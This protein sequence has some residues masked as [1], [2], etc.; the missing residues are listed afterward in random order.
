MEE[1]LEKKLRFEQIHFRRIRQIAG[2]ALRQ[3]S[4]V[5]L[6][7][8]LDGQH[9]PGGHSITASEHVLLTRKVQAICRL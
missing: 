1:Y 6:E 8:L 7:R 4:N 9:A 3:V 2:I 5:D